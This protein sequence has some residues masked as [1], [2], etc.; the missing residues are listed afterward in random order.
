MSPSG[1]RRHVAALQGGVVLLYSQAS[2]GTT[3]GSALQNPVAVLAIIGFFASLVSVAR[4]SIRRDWTRDEV[5][6][7]MNLYCKLPF[8]QLR[9]GNPEVI[10]LAAAMGRTPSS[11]SMKL[12]NLASFD[13]A[14]TARGVA[15]L[16]AASRLDR[17]VWDEFH[18]DWNGMVDESEEILHDV[19][20]GAS[21]EEH[22]FRVAE[23]HTDVWSSVKARRGQQFFRSTVLSSH[24]NRCCITGI[25][26]PELLRASHIIA[27]K[28]DVSNR[29]NPRNGLCL[30]AMQDAAFDRNLIAL[31]EDMRLVLSPSLRD[32][33]THEVLREN[34][35]RFEGREITHPERFQP[36]PAFLQHHRQMLER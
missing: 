17:Q 13:P 34:F 1:K 30:A 16:K 5:I 23:T 10:R 2:F 20:D 15:G 29:L 18:S 19:L 22:E 28:D 32:H 25:A 14:L 21:Q 36:D 8:G 4:G 26:V 3:G 12:C 35:L 33:C 27:W 6:V 7:A 31:D 9:H 24:N 11:V